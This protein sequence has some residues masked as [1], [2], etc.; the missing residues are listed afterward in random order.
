MPQITNTDGGVEKDGTPRATAKDKRGIWFERRVLRHQQP[1][2]EVQG[3]I[4]PV[5]Y[6]EKRCGKRRHR[7]SEECEAFM[8]VHS[9][10]AGN[11]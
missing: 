7:C 1:G 3:D 9:P 5:E 4:W 10:T 8:T 2:R 11:A 6:Q